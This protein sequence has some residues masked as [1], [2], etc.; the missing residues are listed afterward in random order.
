ARLVLSFTSPIT[1]LTGSN[2]AGIAVGDFNADGRSDMAVVNNVVDGSI[3]VMLS[4]P[5][6]SFQLPVS[7]PAGASAFDA[8]AGDLNGDGFADIAVI[9]TALNVL[10]GHGDG[11][12][13]NPVAYPAAPG[14]HS[15][16]IGDFNNDA[17]PD[18][19]TMNTNSASVYLGVGDGTMQP[20]SD[21]A[22]P[23]NNINLVLADVDRDGNLDMATSN[24][25]SIGTVS[26]LRGRGDGSFD[27]PSS[28]YAFSAPVYLAAGDF[29]N[30]GYVDLAVPNSY[31]ATSMSILMN[32]GDGTYGAPHTYG[33]A[34]TGYEIEV[35]DF[36]NDGYD[37]F[38]VRGSSKYMIS[39]G[40]G[41]GTFYPSIDYPT[42][43]GRFESGT[44]GDFN[45]DGA[46]DLAYPSAGGVTVVTNDNADYQNLAGA[47]TFRVSAP[48]STTS[49]S[50]LPMTIE[51]IDADGNIAA[52]FRG[53]VY[54]SSSD[55]QASTASGYA[56]NPLDAGIPYVFTEADGG[57]HSFVGA[58]RLITG[59][60]QSVTVSAPNMQAA[61]VDVEVTGQV[62][63]LGI[64]VPAG[65][66]AGDSFEI[67]VSAVDTAGALA[68]GYSSMVFFTSSDAL[69]G[70]PAD[71]T[72]TPEDAG[73]HSFTVTL[74]TAGN[75]V[76]KA[77]EVGGK[78]SGAGRVN[79]TPLAAASLSLAGSSGPIG[80]SRA[81]TIVARDIYG[82][83]ATSYSDT[84]RF[85]SS[86]PAALVP[87]DLTL[88]NGVGTTMVTFLTVGTQTLTATDLVTP[89]INGTLTSDATP[90]VASAFSITGANSTT[91]GVNQTFVVQVLNTIGQTATDYRGT[92]FF[93]S[94]DVQAGLPQSYTFTTEDGGIHEFTATLRTAGIQSVSARSSDGTIVGS[95]A[96]IAVS[97][98]AYSD[99]QLSV[100]N[101]RD[102]QGH[103]LV[104]AGETIQ[105]SV[106]AT[107]AFGN[108]VTRFAGSVQLSSTDVLA[109]FPSIV[110]FTA[111]DDGL[112]VVPVEL[113]TSTPN[114]I[115]W[116]FIAT[117]VTDP[118][119]TAT[120]TNFEVVN[121]IAT[122]F[123]VSTPTNIG[124]G[125]IFAS[126]VTALDAFGNTAKNYF[127]TVHFST[128]AGTATL[129]ANYTFAAEDGGVHTFDLAIGTAGAQS[130]VV[131][132]M[133]NIAVSGQAGT[134]VRVG[135]FS[136]F[137]ISTTS[138]ASVGV[139]QQVTVT[140]TDA[141]G[142]L[143]DNYTGTVRF[144]SSDPQARLPQEYSF[145][146][147]DGGTQ[148]FSA[149]FNTIGPQSISVIDIDV[150][151]ISTTRSGISVTALRSQVA[152]F[153]ITS[154]TATA[155][156]AL[157][158][159]VSARDSSGNVISGYTGTVS[160]SSSDQ[161]AGLPASYT[162]TAAD[163]G[164][165]AFSVTLKT[166]GRQSL[167]VTDSA[168]PVSSSASIT[169]EPGS[170]ARFAISTPATV[171]SGR[172]FTVR[173]TVYDAYGNIATNFAGTVRLN[174]SDSKA[175]KT[176]YSF[177]A[178]DAGVHEF[179]YTVKATGP[180]TLF[181]TDLDDSSIFAS[182]VINVLSR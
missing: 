51:A 103:V 20:R 172:S 135:E 177:S 100:P 36:N 40:R 87:D 9:G 125:E 110:N 104:T 91:A 75:I 26:I 154:G 118:L 67:T 174:S 129:P 31:V 8:D 137:T 5:D 143:I 109:A 44:H 34:Q 74:R 157:T 102:S 119:T 29:N 161:Q 122:V 37:D 54:I 57:S 60:M 169:V 38:A 182:T 146:N 25:S 80:T 30:D 64:S 82:N 53:V 131:S 165:H 113:R 22:V 170:A 99:L 28:Y 35:A 158:V 160:F 164:S 134:N 107:D 23:G 163:G 88:S 12:F 18:V 168:A 85:T 94:S 66:V 72:F 77:T 155:G 16:R 162:F 145:S 7:F 124:A 150:P 127:G 47:V 179:K 167:Q 55:P 115:V 73:Q 46:V 105:L 133:A 50:V 138:D 86:D 14:S 178:K 76:I 156:Q 78:I 81:V 144:A 114:G 24:T 120:V 84:I 19:G 27:P 41:D 175:G 49:G 128:T 130:I 121:G 42:P 17:I 132:D 89:S 106:R 10:Y 108:T 15:V 70:L 96:G 4:N 1:Y 48:A 141:Y 153:S 90:P 112:V 116:S 136:R 147:K 83:T 142:N 176:E 152:D 159:V 45:G 123:T 151:S 149:T 71:Y 79:V 117:D 181:L 148:V 56:F 140:A 33:I 43:S 69:A 63:Q 93:T 173:L 59:G 11:T 180:Q 61:S 92:V 98:A 62:S 126:K 111:A 21:V 101:G 32:N 39:H 2:P 3:S 95:Q 52:G 58:I 65:A 68:P 171:T 13:D 139:S 6:G 166:A 97:A